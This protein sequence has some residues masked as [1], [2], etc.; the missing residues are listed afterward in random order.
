MLG[1]TDGISFLSASI[2]AFPG[3]HSCGW[4]CPALTRLPEEHI[5]P[6]LQLQLQHLPITSATGIQGMTTAATELLSP[7]PAM[8]HS[9]S[10]TH[11]CALPCPGEPAG[12]HSLGST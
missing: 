4:Q 12:Q 10:P 3:C 6:Q 2:Q 8:Q 1:W 5:H 9:A 11:P 7:R